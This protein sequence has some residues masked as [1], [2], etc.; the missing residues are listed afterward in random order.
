MEALDALLDD[1]K[2]LS[3]DLGTDERLGPS[4]G[5]NG[6]STHG[7]SSPGSNE[8]GDTGFDSASENYSTVKRAPSKPQ[9]VYQPVNNK[10]LQNTVNTSPFPENDNFGL[11]EIMASLDK[12]EGSAEAISATK[13]TRQVS[14]KSDQ[15]DER[16]SVLP[17]PP[18]AVK[19]AP[20]MRPRPSIASKPVVVPVIKTHPAPTDSCG[21][22]VVMASRDMPPPSP[23]KPIGTLGRSPKPPPP[24]TPPR[25][26]NHP[27]RATPNQ[28]NQNQLGHV[29]SQL[30]HS[31]PFPKLQMSHLTKHMERTSSYSSDQS[32]RSSSSSN[33]IASFP[34]HP[35][36][37][38]GFSNNSGSFQFGPGSHVVHSGPLPVNSGSIPNHSNI[39]NQFHRVQQ[40]QHSYHHQ[41]KQFNQFQQPSNLQH[42]SAIPRPVGYAGSSVSDQTDG[43]SNIPDRNLIN[44]ALTEKV[45]IFS[46]EGSYKWIPIERSMST[47]YVTQLVA[48][49]HRT[50]FTAKHSLLEYNPQLATERILEEHEKVVEVVKKWGDNKNELH[51]FERA[52][53]WLLF[54]NPQVLMDRVT[55]EKQTPREERH[56]YLEQWYPPNGG[57]RYPG[58]DM[59]GPR[60][61]ETVYTKEDKKDKWSK[62]YIEI[63]KDKLLIFKKESNREKPPE[64][65]LDMK[66]FLVYRSLDWRKH[67]KSPLSNGFCVKMGH[68]QNFG[69]VKKN[70]PTDRIK[71]FA[72][73]DEFSELR[74][75]TA[76]RM[77][78]HGMQLFQNYRQ[79][80]ASVDQRPSSLLSLRPQS[81][82]P[83]M[84]PLPVNS[85]SRP[86]SMES[87][88]QCDSIH[89]RAYQPSS[90]N[91]MILNQPSI[92]HGVI[93]RDKS[94]HSNSHVTPNS[95]NSK[96]PPMTRFYSGNQEPVTS[97]A[98]FPA[99]PSFVNEIKELSRRIQTENNQPGS[100]GNYPNHVQH[101]DQLAFDHLPPPPPELMLQ[102]ARHNHQMSHQG[103]GYQTLSNR[104]RP[105]PP[106][107][108]PQTRL[109][110]S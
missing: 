76:L 87:H 91:S 84:G 44:S 66:D 102:G 70:S 47:R 73:E 4:R 100:Y 39:Q 89:D 32:D 93:L 21:P 13:R 78:K 46:A 45:Q 28:V 95:Y 99:P 36:S 109:H 17:K 8:T 15:S 94:I 48:E 35:V 3:K 63:R 37:P 5:E 26:S 34:P 57:F 60:I 25:V 108:N 31:G 72:V 42:Q 97:P 55:A 86:S 6:P 33:Q 80:M 29:Q 52:D 61:C 50:R 58:D 74:W 18:I 90:G 69:Q 71:F 10:P 85:H 23:I 88:D 64:D 27:P 92:P 1:L 16:P 68:I 62:K 38:G 14:F 49:K 19:P 43:S 110:N 75:M 79:T 22:D 103:N 107:R 40:Q 98:D 81:I 53:K 11:D 9:P 77:V 2:I 104:P 65:V 41:Q 96:P 83:N 12:L 56:R 51:F 59:A 106:R 54:A 67:F 82:G 20:P 30:G 7:S 105:P 24:A 101:H